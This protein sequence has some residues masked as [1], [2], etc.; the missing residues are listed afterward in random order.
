MDNYAAFYQGRRSTLLKEEEIRLLQRTDVAFAT[1]PALAER[2]E[3]RCARIH[4]LANAVHPDFLTKEGF[5]CPPDLASRPKPVIGYVGS[6]SHWVD[7]DLL[8]YI[9]SKRPN[10]SFVMVG[11][12]DRIRIPKH[13]SNLHFTGEKRY[14]DVPAYVDN[15]DVCIIPFV[16]NELTQTVNPVKL[17]EYLARGKPVVATNTRA[18]RPFAD[19][20]CVAKDREHFLAGIDEA[21][22]GNKGKGAPRSDQ[23]IRLAQANTWDHRVRAVEEILGNLLKQ[24]R[25]LSHV[26]A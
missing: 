8:C 18:M 24:K 11:P 19:V 20:C 23:R 3:N 13:L 16:V 7:L 9:A 15:M 22:R 2:F 1:D 25:N 6:L 5:P 21:L 17:Y 4:L 14:E 26:S 12:T 10:W